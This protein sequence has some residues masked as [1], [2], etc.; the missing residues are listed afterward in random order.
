M[1]FAR[2]ISDILVG[3]NS[4]FNHDQ[5]HIMNKDILKKTSY[6]PICKRSINYIV[7]I[8]LINDKNQVCLIQEAKQS[9]RGK[10]YLPAGRVEPNENLIE[11]AIREA[12]EETGYL[13]EPLCLCYVEMDSMS[14]W[15]RFTF[16]ARI[17]GGSLKT[18]EQA[19]EESLQA[20][21]FDIDEF[22]NQ[23]FLKQLRSADF[24]RNVYIGLKYYENYNLNSNSLI[25]NNQYMKLQDKFNLILPS[26]NSHQHILFTFLILNNNYKYCLL[27]EKQEDLFINSMLP[28]VIIVPDVYLKIEKTIL[29]FALTSIIFPECFEL[30]KDSIK[31]T[32]K[33]LLAVDYNGRPQSDNKKN[34]GI[35]LMFL[36]TLNNDSDKTEQADKDLGVY[37]TKA[38]FKWQL[39][40][41]KEDLLSEKLKQPYN[42]ITL[43]SI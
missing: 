9:C 14:T 3:Q 31:Y 30:S 19:D 20:K 18:S 35:Q 15:F 8:V 12:K 42:F 38:P 32:K 40:D 34:D 11:A 5:I 25:D 6:V 22:N 28:S 37:R 10:Y 4:V 16:L 7:G 13:I 29:D 33:C 1:K 26:L 36:I 27:Y 39:V 17:I 21:W 24:I 41:E 43:Q 23:N 2:M